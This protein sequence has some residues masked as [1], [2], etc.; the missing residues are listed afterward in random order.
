MRCVLPSLAVTFT[1]FAVTHTIVTFSFP[2]YTIFRQTPS[3]E[4]FITV[5]FRSKTEIT[6]K[7]VQNVPKTAQTHRFFLDIRLSKPGNTNFTVFRSHPERKKTHHPEDREN[8]LFGS[9]L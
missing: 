3:F 6:R 8:I 2:R 9:F 4:S 7:S 5:F 1:G